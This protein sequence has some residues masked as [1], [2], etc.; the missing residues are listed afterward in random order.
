M[1][2]NYIHI[3]LATIIVFVALQANAQYFND[4]EARTSV[5][6]EYKFNKNLS[7]AGTYYLYMN[8]NISEYKKSVLAGEIGYKITKWMK[9]GIEYRYGMDYP[10]NYHEMGYSFTFDY[11]LLEKLKI[12]YKPMFI[13]EFRSLNQEHLAAYPMEYYLTNRVTLGYEIARKT[14]LYVFTENYQQIEK[15]N[16][17]FYRQKSALGAAFKAG[18]RSEIDT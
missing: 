11:D 1:K 9:T 5:S 3:L 18:D 2:A 6:L 17:Q 15:G 7:I 14:E 13:M 16:F 12:K 8:K 10:D 4:W